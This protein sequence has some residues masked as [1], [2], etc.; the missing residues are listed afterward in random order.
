MSTKTSIQDGLATR[1]GTIKTANGYTT[2]VSKIYVDTIPMGLDLETWE[3]P[4]ILVISDDDD[5]EI[6]QQCLHGH[7][8]VEL[9]LWHNLVADSVMHQFVRDVYK[10]IYADSPT[11]KRNDGF[12]G[13]HTSV[14][15]MLP[16]SIESDLN[17]IDANRCYVCTFQIDYSANLYDL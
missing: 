11:A 1:L 14:F 4:A 16:L 12:R 17:M 15:N 3:L 9:Q 7:W 10:A 2:N 6:K 8:K 5:P 13:L